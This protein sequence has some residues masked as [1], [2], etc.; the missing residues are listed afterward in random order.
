MPSGVTPGAYGATSVWACMFSAADAI[1]RDIRKDLFMVYV[2]IVSLLCCSIILLVLCVGYSCP[3]AILRRVLY[4]SRKAN[5]RFAVM[6]DAVRLSSQ[7][8]PA[9]M[10]PARP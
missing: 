2:F 5:G 10:S 3:A 8:L 1:T 9:A 6:S 4:I 7:S